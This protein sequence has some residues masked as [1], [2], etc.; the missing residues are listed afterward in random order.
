MFVV[1]CGCILVGTVSWLQFNFKDVVGFTNY[2]DWLNLCSGFSNITKLADAKALCDWSCMSL[3][4]HISLF[5]LE[6]FPVGMRRF[7]AGLLIVLTLSLNEATEQLLKFCTWHI[8]QISLYVGNINTFIS[9]SEVSCH[10]RQFW[11]ECWEH[12][13]TI[14]VEQKHTEWLSWQLHGC[15]MLSDDLQS[16]WPQ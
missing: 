3:R 9:Y 11:L 5:I 2:V 8:F 15:T 7:N 13:Q 12:A 14:S 1:S 10:A 6:N 4:S 16:M